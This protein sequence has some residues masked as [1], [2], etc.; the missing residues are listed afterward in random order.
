MMCLVDFLIPNAC[1]L[2]GTPAS[3]CEVISSS[4]CDLMI[5]LIIFM[6]TDIWHLFD[7]SQHAK[8]SH[9]CGQQKGGGRRAITSCVAELL[10]LNL[11]FVEKNNGKNR[12]HVDIQI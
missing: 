1:P 7:S 12:K 11:G 2:A 8:S 9:W 5:L 4:I 3:V 6:D 10:C